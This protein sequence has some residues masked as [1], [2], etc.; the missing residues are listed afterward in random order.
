MDDILDQR[1][2]AGIDIFHK[3]LQS[4]FTVEDV[5]AGIPLFVALTHI[6]ERKSDAG[7]EE[8]QITQTRC[9]RLVVIDSLAEYR[10]VGMEDYRRTRVI[11]LADHLQAACRLA[12]GVFLHVHLAVAVN[13][14]AEIVGECVDTAH[15]DTVETA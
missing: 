9:E 7:V 6:G 12:V 10:G 1:L 2:L 15:A 13:L 3:L 5:A 4:L 8:S 11:G 14:G